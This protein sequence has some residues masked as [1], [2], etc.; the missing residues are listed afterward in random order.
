MPI[1]QVATEALHDAMARFDRDFR[2]APE[3]A[4]WGQNRAHQ[5]AIEHDGKHYTVKQIV[6]IATGTPVSEFS[7]GQ[8][9]GDANQFVTLAA[10]TSSSC[11]DE[12]PTGCAMS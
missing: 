9:A 6:S 10:S 7:G 11:G 4:G 2:D 12:I 1:P 8:A 3:W 5:Y